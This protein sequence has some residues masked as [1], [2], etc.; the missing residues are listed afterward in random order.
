MMETDLISNSP[1]T[2]ISKSWANKSHIAHAYTVIKKQ[3][4]QKPQFTWKKG[5]IFSKTIRASIGVKHWA[6][7]IWKS[8]TGS[9]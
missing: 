4:D 8:K 5:N 6:V 2:H 3:R 1:H 7:T 9:W